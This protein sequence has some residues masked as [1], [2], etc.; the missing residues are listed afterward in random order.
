MKTSHTPPAGANSPPPTS[1][2]WTNPTLLRAWLTAI[3]D[4]GD[5]LAALSWEGTRR[6]R[7][8]V[9]SRYERRRRTREAEASLHKLVLA[10]EAALPTPAT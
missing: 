8:R 3:R 10:A 5:D 9:L 6:V 2:D 4:T 7:R 1:F